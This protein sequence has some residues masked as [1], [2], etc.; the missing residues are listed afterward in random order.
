M[1][2]PGPVQAVSVEER[3]ARLEAKLEARE[4]RE[5]D[6]KLCLCVFSGELDKQLA[7]LVIA[8]SAAA[9]GMDVELFFTFWA[10]ASLRDPKKC[11]RKGILGRLVGR[12]LPRG[13]RD[14]PLSRFHFAGFGPTMVRRLMRKKGIVSLEELFTLA[15][16]L[17]IK[18]HVCSMSMDLMEFQREE[19]IDYPD[20]DVCGATT[21]VELMSAAKSTLFI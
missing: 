19:F 3:L 18:I 8:T 5:R 1:L 9:S 17:G 20:L 15:A 6:N 13:V 2:E 4:R 11:S 10:T 16:D 14:L 7:A 21:F 12:M